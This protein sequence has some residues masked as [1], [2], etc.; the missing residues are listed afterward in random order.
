[1]DW[2]DLP[3]RGS[4][5]KDV[6]A[7]WT[8]CGNHEPVQWRNFTQ[9][10]RPRLTSG[11]LFCVKMMMQTH[12]FLSFSSFHKPSTLNFTLGGVKKHVKKTWQ[13]TE[14]LST[15]RISTT[16][17]YH[18]WGDQSRSRSWR[19]FW[20]TGK[21]Q[22]CLLPREIGPMTSIKKNGK[23]TLYYLGAPSLDGLGY[24]VRWKG[25]AKR[26]SQVSACDK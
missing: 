6:C 5:R 13:K 17:S 21:P 2:D 20:V 15:R 26:S 14:L 1:M 25:D 12:P 19:P 8:S 24:Q 3:T 10:R 11:S 4:H 9:C 16:L 7:H 18:L 23:G 22:I